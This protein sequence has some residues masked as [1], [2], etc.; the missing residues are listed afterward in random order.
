MGMMH[1]QKIHHTDQAWA[2]KK[3]KRIFAFFRILDFS[4][5]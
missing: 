5:A 4:F 3:E 2:K 1:G